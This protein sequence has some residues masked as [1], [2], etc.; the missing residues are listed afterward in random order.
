M[1]QE[2]LAQKGVRGFSDWVTT[3]TG[4]QRMQ[5]NK[6]FEDTETPE[7]DHRHY[8][9]YHENIPRSAVLLEVLFFTNGDSV[10]AALTAFRRG[11]FCLFRRRLDSNGSKYDCLKSG[12]V[13]DDT[14]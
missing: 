1:A 7:Q 14:R 12:T 13:A 3:A 8:S 11:A 6:S 4:M 5:D 2:V 10:L 9:R